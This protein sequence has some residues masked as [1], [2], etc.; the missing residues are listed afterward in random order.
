MQVRLSLQ[1]H[2]HGHKEQRYSDS[3][4]QK[5][6]PDARS[7]TNKIKLSYYIHESQI[8]PTVIQQHKIAREKL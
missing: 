1:S 4:G 2:E 3:L 5:I 8:F 6:E 7:Y